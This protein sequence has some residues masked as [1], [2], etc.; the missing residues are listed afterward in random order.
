V[1]L[2]TA[3]TL[4]DAKLRRL[5]RREQARL[6]A[7]ADAWL[8]RAHQAQQL[9]YYVPVTPDAV[10]VHTSTAR[11]VGVVGGN[12]SGK[13]DLALV[14]WAI[15]ATGI[16]PHSLAGLY[17]ATKRRAPIR[18]RLVVTSL[19]TAWDLNLKPKL[20]WWSWNG[21]LTPEG[22]QGDP[23]LGHWG[24]VPPDL[25]LDGDWGKSWSE[26]HRT[27]TLA[28]GSALHVMSYE[29]DAQDFAQGAFHLILEDELGP[30]HVH[31]ENKMRVVDYGG[32]VLTTGTPPDD[33]S[34]AVTAAWFHDG[35]Y[36]PGLAEASPEVFAVTLWTEQ[37]R[38]LDQADVAWVAQGLTEEQREARLHG[39]FLHLAGLVLPGFTERRRTWCFRCLADVLGAGET[40]PT[41]GSRDLEA[42]RHVWDE[43]DL[44]WPGPREWP[45]LFYM[46]PHQ[47]RPTACAWTKVDPHDGWWQVAELDVAGPA[48]EVKRQVEAYERAHDLHPV[49]R[50]GD[51]KIGVQGNQFAELV[52]G[53]RFTIKRAF[54]EV[55]FA[56]EDANTNFTVGRERLLE[57]FRPNPLTRVPKLRI[58]TACRRTIHQVTHFTWNQG[59][60]TWNA[61]LKEQPSRKES[62]FP[63]LLRY[64]A[65]DD[66][67]FLFCHRFLRMEPIRV[68]AG[69]RGRNPRTGW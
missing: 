17:P 67:T 19:V 20:Q 4:S 23:D 27:L 58:H 34:A 36:L 28:N 43:E 39:R 30:E 37:N 22:L 61:D 8:R 54:E 55:G 5:P 25:L 62:D 9:R 68:G 31:R 18:A 47:A 33:R 60:R 56:Y 13:T 63:A 26:K 2:L 21:K 44:E 42:Y 6:K 66:P 59:R 3:T 53:E 40:C 29:Q 65:M 51:P 69:G 14:E 10:A 41:C 64:L 7:E 49:W 32:Q 24:W 35:V 48:E 52:A 15:Q 50:K 16:V 38:T 1:D 11:E 12:R 45:T 46:D 57:A